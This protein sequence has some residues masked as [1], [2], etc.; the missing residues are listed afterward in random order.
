MTLHHSIR[1]E[2]RPELEAL[3]QRTV[4]SST[5]YISSLYGSLLHRAPAPAEA[6]TLVG[7]M[8]SGVRPASIALG[9]VGGTE[10]QRNVVVSSYNLFLN[11]QPSAGEVH[12]WLTQLAT[13]LSESQLEATFL[14]SD[15]FFQNHG[16]NN[17]G[18]V[19]AVY[20]QVLGR[21][22]D[23]AGLIYWNQRLLDGTTRFAVAFGIVTSSEANSRTINDAYHLLLGR[24]PDA[25]GL[26]YWVGQCTS[27][28][29][30]DGMIAVI[31]SCPEYIDLSNSGPGGGAGTGPFFDDPFCADPY[32][33]GPIPSGLSGGSGGSGGSG[34]VGSGGSG[35]GSGGSGGG[36]GGSGSGSG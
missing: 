26:G 9:V 3:E 34:S 10:F 7:A 20:E 27:G 31:A 15:E 16:A 14:A 17:T 11:R 1:R 19:N 25:A 22:P 8:D 24:G 29:A 2:C 30:A 5:Q 28:L 18:W 32:Q 21:P 4:P 12:Y 35:G 33:F 6:A 13:G 36:S 23:S